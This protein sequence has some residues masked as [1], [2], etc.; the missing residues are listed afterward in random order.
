VSTGPL[1]RPERLRDLSRDAALADSLRVQVR[2]FGGVASQRLRLD[3]VV[4]GRGQ[5]TGSIQDELVGRAGDFAGELPGAERERLLQLL[6]GDDF[7]APGEPRMFLP[8][9]VIGSV[10]V[11]LGDG[12][13]G[14]YRDALNPDATTSVGDVLAQ[15]MQI[16]EA[17]V[18]PRA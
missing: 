3:A 16:A 6:G 7:A 4:T 2:I 10:T 1:E 5:V 14:T 13:V 12:P 8:D 11:V 18:P 17:M 15:V 9:T